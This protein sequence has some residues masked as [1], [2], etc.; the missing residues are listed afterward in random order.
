MSYPLFG[1]KKESR[2]PLKE[3]YKQIHE[4][5]TS[6]QFAGFGILCKDMIEFLAA[7]GYGGGAIETFRTAFNKAIESD[8]Y[9]WEA[10]YP[11][12]LANLGALEGYPSGM[13]EAASNQK[14]KLPP[15]LCDKELGE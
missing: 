8:R 4:L 5:G 10:F 15:E 12:A 14:F 3:L 7:R 9:Y 1:R 11:E 2:P 13:A 6:L